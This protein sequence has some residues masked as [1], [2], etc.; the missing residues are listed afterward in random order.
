M[1]INKVF[2]IGRA[3]AKPELRYVNGGETAVASFSIACNYDKDSA[4]FF[5]I[6]VWR[7]QAENCANYIDKGDRVAIEGMLRQDKWQDKEGGNRYKIKIV[8]NR[9]QFLASKKD[10]QEKP[11]E[12][13]PMHKEDSKSDPN[14]EAPF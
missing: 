13:P 1:D 6:D 2:L 10:K 3:T 4:Y 5:D 9:V 11:P 14:D 12:N 8:A 7:K